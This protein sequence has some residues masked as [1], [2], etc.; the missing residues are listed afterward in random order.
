VLLKEREGINWRARKRIME[1]GMRGRDNK[2]RTMF[3]MDVVGTSP[4]ILMWDF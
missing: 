3:L 4:P 2:E 1:K